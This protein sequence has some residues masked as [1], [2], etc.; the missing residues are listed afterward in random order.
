MQLHCVRVK[1]LG[2]G[3]AKLRLTDSCIEALFIGPKFIGSKAVI[4]GLCLRMVV[5]ALPKMSG[6]YRADSTSFP[7]AVPERLY[8][9][10]C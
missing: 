8:K 1:E 6:Q 3:T 4:K 2:S 9:F 5:Q 10:K 7:E